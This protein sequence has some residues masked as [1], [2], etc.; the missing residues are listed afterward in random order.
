MGEVLILL[1]RFLRYKS[2][3]LP[4][5]ENSS[6]FSR[7]SESFSEILVAMSVFTDFIGVGGEQF[8]SFS[9]MLKI[10]SWKPGI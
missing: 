1:S 8:N 6:Q 5:I 2:F 9:L 4:R 10:V 7:S 3:N